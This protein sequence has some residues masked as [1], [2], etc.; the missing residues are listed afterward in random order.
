MVSQF[1]IRR[2][3]ELVAPSDRD[4]FESSLPPDDKAIASCYIPIYPGSQLWFEYNLDG[5]HPPNASYLFK[6][7]HNG[8]L[9]TSFDCTAKQ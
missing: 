9:V 7:L 2:L 6:M 8:K 3:P 4:P 1:D 5:P